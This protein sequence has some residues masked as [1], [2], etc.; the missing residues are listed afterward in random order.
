MSVGHRVAVE[1]ESAEVASKDQAVTRGHSSCTI[2]SIIFFGWGGVVCVVVL[3]FWCFLRGDRK[4]KKGWGMGV[5]WKSWW[6]VKDG[7]IVRSPMIAVA[8]V[9]QSR[10][11]WRNEF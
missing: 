2:G 5:L 1:V 11:G 6:G 4:S 8:R 7:V 9:Y 10:A 3:M